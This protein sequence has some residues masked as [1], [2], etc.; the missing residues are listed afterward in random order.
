MVAAQQSRRI[1]MEQGLVMSAQDTQRKAE[2]KHA[3][4]LATVM[5]AF[6]VCWTP[7][8]TIILFIQVS[9]ITLYGFLQYVLMG[10]VNYTRM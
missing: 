9:H 8:F 10:L 7:V 5:G 2:T 1:A 3:K 4:V 6:L